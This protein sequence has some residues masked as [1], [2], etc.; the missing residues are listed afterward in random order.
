MTTCCRWR[1]GQRREGSGM[2]A[3]A[4][5]ARKESGGWQEVEMGRRACTFWMVRSAITGSTNARSAPTRGCPGSFCDYVK[6]N[7]ASS[8]RRAR[9]PA[10][11]TAL[12]APASASSSRRYS[13][14]PPLVARTGPR[15]LCRPIS[16]PPRPTTSRTMPPLAAGRLPPKK[17]RSIPT[18]PDRRA[19][20]L[21]SHFRSLR[22]EPALYSSSH[23]HS[24]L[25]PVN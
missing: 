9:L 14:T 25:P 7:P 17:V 5:A 24:T 8:N 3:Q 18:P 23:C 15:G 2:R 21:R 11:Q 16:V 6:G 20:I 4:V 1:E 19:L 22:A 10:Q 12:G 13:H